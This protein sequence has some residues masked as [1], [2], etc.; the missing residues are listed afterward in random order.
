MVAKASS[1]TP[2]CRP[3]E[4]SRFNK[5]D[6]QL[7]GKWCN[8]RWRLVHDT[9]ENDANVDLHVVPVIPVVGADE[10]LLHAHESFLSS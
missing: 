3:D 2:D 9:L 6:H 5:V 4:D 1:V 10:L 8:R 7:I